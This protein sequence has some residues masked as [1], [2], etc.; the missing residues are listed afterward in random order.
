MISRGNPIGIEVVGRAGMDPGALQAEM[1]E[2]HG[3]VESAERDRSYWITKQQKLLDLRRGPPNKIKDVPWVGANNHHWPL[4]DGVIRRWKPGIISLVLEANPIAFFYANRPDQV[5]AARTAQSFWHWQMHAISNLTQKIHRLSDYV[6]QYGLAYVQEGWEY[7]TDRV[8]RVVSSA[9]LFP[10]GPEAAHKQLLQ[11]MQA[12]AQQTAQAIEQ[13]Q[14]S[15]EQAQLPTPPTLEQ[16]VQETIIKEYGLGEADGQQIDLATRGII[17]GAEYV[18]IYYSQVVCDK[19]AL[20]VLSPLD[21]VVPS[22][23]D[24]VETADF[25][26]IVFRLTE[27]EIRRNVRDGWFEAGPAQEVIARMAK[28]QGTFSDDRL[29]FDGRTA[30]G[31]EQLLTT[32][33]RLD[34]VDQHGGRDEPSRVPLWK[35]YC[36]LDINGDGIREQCVVWYDPA[37]ATVLSVSEY[38]LPFRE[39]PITAYEFEHTDARPYQARGIAEY[40][41]TFQLQTNRLHNAR[42]DAIQVTLSPMFTVRSVVANLNRNISFRPGG[43][44]PVTDPSDFQPVLMNTQG[45]FQLLQEENLTKTLAEQYIGVFDSSVTNALQPTERRTATEVEA[46]NA[47][48]SSVFGADAG[49]FQNSFAKTLR[50]LWQLWRDLG[51]PGVYYRVTGEDEPRFITKAEINFDYDI[52]PAG[53]PANTS[54]ALALSR[55]RE[56]LQIFLND[57]TGYID[58]RELFKWWFDLTDPNLSK[59]IVRSEDQARAAQM[60]MQAAM[61]IAEE[62]KQPPPAAF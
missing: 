3:R 15:E 58:H 28:R 53:T 44:V 27:D 48:I 43:L 22:R 37:S 33:D 17:D 8:C 61:A 29:G 57:Q 16:F 2:L 12:Q 20:D 49:L 42:L 25:I 19:P 62:N 47:S 35:L 14:I 46:V 60:V 40:L 59:R 18:K 26:A 7:K 38:H 31:R 50:K 54:K 36:H 34:G 45:L 10:G 9:S 1:K 11:Q 4:I 39:W 55:A 24:E 52:A 56:G 21:V 51:P 5:P 23:T 32:Q 13:G 6:G 41:K 30:G